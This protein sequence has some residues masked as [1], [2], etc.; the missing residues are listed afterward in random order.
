MPQ[1]PGAAALMPDA[2]ATPAKAEALMHAGDWRN[3]SE[4]DWLTVRAATAALI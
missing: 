3:G 4:K 1:N 2:R